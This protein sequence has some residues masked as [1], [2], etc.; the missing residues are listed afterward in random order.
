[1]QSNLG[2]QDLRVVE[3]LGEFCGSGVQSEIASNG[4]DLGKTRVARRPPGQ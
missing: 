4:V 3:H 1:M 2:H